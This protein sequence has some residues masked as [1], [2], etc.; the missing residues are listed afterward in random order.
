MCL[1]G[2]NDWPRRN[3]SSKPTPMKPKKPRRRGP[4]RDGLVLAEKIRQTIENDPITIRDKE[5]LRRKFGK[6]DEW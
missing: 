1:L 3:K 2:V 5:T 4:R 6:Q